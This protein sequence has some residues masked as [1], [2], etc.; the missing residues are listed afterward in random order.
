MSD[1]ILYGGPLNYPPDSI[2]VT[3]MFTVLD[4][5]AELFSVGRGQFT[6][7]NMRFDQALECYP[8]LLLPGG[9]PGFPVETNNAARR[10]VIGMDVDGNVIILVINSGEFTLYELAR[11]LP[12]TDLNL[13]MA[14]N[15]DGGRSTG[16]SVNL[17]PEQRTINSAVELPIVLEV[18]PR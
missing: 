9:Q 8:M 6:P 12:Q 14:L 5:Q 10:T 4:G 15:L 3:G 11:W 7:Q 13:D 18:G 2:G 16:I 1:G 17:G